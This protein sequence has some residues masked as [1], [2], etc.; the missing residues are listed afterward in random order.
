MLEELLEEVRLERIRQ[1][2]RFGW[3][4]MHHPTWWLTILAEEF[5]EFAHDVCDHE[6]EAGNWKKNM[7]EEL[8][9][10]AAVALAAIEDLDLQH[11]MTGSAGEE[12]QW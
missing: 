3:P 6:F 8:V 12:D 5:G 10:I 11:D 4:R 7:R 1:D 2:D 9:Q